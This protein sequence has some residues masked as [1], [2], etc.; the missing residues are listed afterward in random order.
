MTIIQQLLV[1]V[2]VAK[3]NTDQQADKENVQGMNKY[4]CINIHIITNEDAFLML[5]GKRLLC[6]TE[7]D[8]CQEELCIDSHRQGN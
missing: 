7:T 8:S 1:D 2:L 3:M 4:E 5:R 6:I